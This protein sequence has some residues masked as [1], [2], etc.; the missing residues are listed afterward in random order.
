[1]RITIVQGAFLPVPALRGGAVEKAWHALGREFAARGHEVTHI[2]RRC[3]GLPVESMEDGVR[4]I[5]IR[6][7]DTPSRLWWLKT[8]DLIYS[9]GAI[10]RLP[11]ADV[12]VTHT[13]FLPLL[14]RMRPGAGRPYV[15]VGRAPRGQ[16]RL[17]RNA[18][19]LQAPS[20]IIA[21]AIRSE[22]GDC[23]RPAVSVIGYPVPDL[24][25]R[26]DGSVRVPR[27][28]LYT[29]RVH[30]EKGIDLLISGF[31]RF[32]S[33]AAGEGWTLQVTGPWE[34]ATGGGGNGYVEALRR[35]V[36]DLGLFGRVE[37]TG[38][39]FE[40]G[41]LACAYG[42]ASAFVYPSLAE[43]G[44]TFGLAVLE[45]MSAGLPA[46]VSSLGCFGDF[47]EPGANGFRFDHRGPDPEG[48]LADALARLA[49]ALEGE[50]GETMRSAA[51]ATARRFSLGSVAT[52]FLDDFESA[53]KDV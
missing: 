47:I 2:S 29:G 15:H 14:A 42:E 18:A 40:P 36:A 19:V 43:A 39:F 53:L 11:A 7:F 41:R 12:L 49:F 52:A 37:F 31:A 16:M 46:V 27:R 32:V 1:M 5:R 26:L 3:D 33:T 24:S 6:G 13:F 45:A 21:D 22:L 25:I 35:R 9:L 44:E 50:S 8:L 34:T 38:P 10:R 28:L 17:Y 23:I 51:R 4:H 48:A 30:P 20:R